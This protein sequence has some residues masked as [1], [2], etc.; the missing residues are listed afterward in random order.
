M[1]SSLPQF[2]SLSSKPM[3]TK[4]KEKRAATRRHTTNFNSGHIEIDE[5]HLSRT[6]LRG[7]KRWFLWCG[8][9]GLLVIATVNLMVC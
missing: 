7:R 3:W 6:G 5:Y 2:S 8:V 4:A 9:I 1:N